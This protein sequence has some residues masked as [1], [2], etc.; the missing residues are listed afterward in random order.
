MKKLV[1]VLVGVATLLLIL[2]NSQSQA[3]P[4]YYSFNFSQEGFAGGEKVTGSFS[5]WSSGGSLTN[6]DS[7][8]MSLS[9][10]DDTLIFSLG[11]ADLQ[12]FYFHIVLDG[13]LTIADHKNESPYN[14]HRSPYYY[15]AIK[16]WGTRESLGMGA[17]RESL[18]QVGKDGSGSLMEGGFYSHQGPGGNLIRS[19]SPVVLT[20]TAT[21]PEP[22]TMLL[23]GT[24][25]VGLAGVNRKK[26]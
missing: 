26:K 3:S 9:A 19:S 20:P 22:A 11:L 2:I 10:N 24:G 6:L 25:L 12:Q 5:G 4:I 14:Y 16:V 15:E 18:W 21:V 7:F 17:W 13:D 8:Q 23:F 1:G